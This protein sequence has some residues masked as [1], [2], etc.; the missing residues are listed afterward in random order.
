MRSAQAILKEFVSHI[1]PP[2]G[3]AIVLTEYNSSG[4]I[5]LNWVAHVATWTRGNS[6]FTMKSSLNCVRLIQ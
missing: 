5:P 2:P 4:P 3:C 1:G 6:Y